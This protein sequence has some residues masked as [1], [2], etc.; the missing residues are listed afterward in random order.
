MLHAQNNSTHG[1]SAQSRGRGAEG[2]PG[3]AE[4]V[5][6]AELSRDLLDIV[7]DA[8]GR[9]IGN[10]VIRTTDLYQSEATEHFPD[11]LVEWSGA[12]PVR[13][14]RSDKIGRIERDYSY[15]R[16]G[17]HVQSGLFIVAGPGIT[18]GRLDREVS[19]LDFAPTIWEALGV[20]CDDFDGS[21]IPEIVDAM[22][23][24]RAPDER[25]TMRA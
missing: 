21:A 9:R 19:I 25:T 10:R 13:A 18:P 20:D 6:I 22:R 2:R 17:E 3:R 8:T 1:A 5:P 15:C 12:D 23:M 11:L 14:I 4:Y 16:T 7:N 24:R